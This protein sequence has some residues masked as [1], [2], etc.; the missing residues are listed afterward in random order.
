MNLKDGSLHEVELPGWASVN[1]ADWTTDGKSVLA[2]A[3]RPSGTASVVEV[4]PSGRYDVRLE[5]D[6]NVRFM[7]AIQS[8]DGKHVLLEQMTGENNVWMVENF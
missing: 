8:P 4:E 5:G 1:N 7:W 2:I 3:E 6:K